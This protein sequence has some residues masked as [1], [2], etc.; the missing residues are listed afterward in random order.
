LPRDW[1]RANDIQHGQVIRLE[2]VPDITHEATGLILR[3]VKWSGVGNTRLP[4]DHAKSKP[5]ATQGGIS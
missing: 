1:C 4:G 3:V 2:E 5:T